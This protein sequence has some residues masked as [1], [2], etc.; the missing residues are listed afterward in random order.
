MFKVEK[1]IP[2]PD[3]QHINKK[4]VRDVLSA[5][6]VGDSIKIKHAQLPYVHR[7]MVEL[8]MKCTTRSMSKTHRR[9][10]RIS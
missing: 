4:T 5:M 6:E 2:I 10:W 8:D 7:L 9:V 1:G 3:I